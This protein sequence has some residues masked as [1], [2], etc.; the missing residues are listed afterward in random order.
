MTETSAE[1]RPMKSSDVAMAYESV[2]MSFAT[3]AEERERVLGRSDEEVEES[4]ERYRSFLRTDPEGAWVAKDKGA[5]VGVAV[6]IRRGGLWILSIFAVDESQRGKGVG[7]ELLSR[8]MGYGEGS[9]AAMIAS[10]THP[11]AMRRYALAGFILHPTFTAEGF[12]RRESILPSLPVHEGDESHLEMAA[13]VDKKLRGGAHGPDI[14]RLLDTG[15]RLLVSERGGEMGYAVTKEGST[16]IVAATHEEMARDL[17]W[18]A[19]ADG[20]PGVES[21]ARWITARQK[22][23]V[24]I[25]L[26]AGLSLK[27]DGPICIKGEPGT[28]FPY[29]PSGLYL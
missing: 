3:E 28:L 17:L 21:T 8:A 1:I 5:V 11:A 12:V 6:S 27:P 18:A 26:E 14:D 2:A 22:W 29:L 24:D 10:S 20:R 19:L 7:R 9:S 13:E 15:N 23:A 16:Q 4:H 25:A